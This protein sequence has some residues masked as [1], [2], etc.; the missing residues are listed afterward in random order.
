MPGE[1]IYATKATPHSATKL[2]ASDVGHLHAP[3]HKKRSSSKPNQKTNLKKSLQ[4]GTE[5]AAE[6]ESLE[7]SALSAEDSDADDNDENGA[8][9]DEGSSDAE[10]P[11]VIAPSG[12]AVDD[13][14]HQTGPAMTYAGTHTSP[15]RLKQCLEAEKQQE[16]S[17]DEGYEGVNLVS[18]SEKDGSEM[19][20]L[21]ERAIVESE[22]TN[23]PSGQPSGM[24]KDEPQTTEAPWYTSFD[25]GWE[26]VGVS[27]PFDEPP[28]FFHEQISQMGQFNFVNS[29]DSDGSDSFTGSAS[30]FENAND[31]SLDLPI[32]PAQRRVHFA[33]PPHSEISGFSLYNDAPISMFDAL[34]DS[35]VMD[36]NVEAGSDSSSGYECES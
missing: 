4:V 3:I 29:I 35:S 12:C 6:G 24:A 1:A 36:S 18:D 7:D 2:F 33:E 25:G 31:E 17:D 20:Y 34:P 32:S 23:E 19:D 26:G 11:D 14:G 22:D 16:S 10:D 9:A 15:K 30:N 27:H 28:D 8:D 21:E 13:E 5:K